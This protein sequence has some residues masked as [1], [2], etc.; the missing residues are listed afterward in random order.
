MKQNCFVMKRSGERVP[1]NISKIIKAING[2]NEDE[3]SSSLEQVSE[4]Q[5]QDIANGI[6]QEALKLDRDLSVEEIQDRVEEGLMATGKYHVARSYITYRYNHNENRKMSDIDQK[7][8]NL[9]E[10]NNEE[11]KQENSNKNPTI[12]SVQRDYMAGE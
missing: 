11:V 2:A 8:A 4:Q 5:A 12:L 1:F 7:I 9:I 10:L 3:K 6:Y